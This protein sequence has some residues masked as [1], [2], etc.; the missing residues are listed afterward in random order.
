MLFVWGNASTTAPKGFLYL[1]DQPNTFTTKRS[2]E[3]FSR[4]IKS[5]IQGSRSSPPLSRDASS[6]TVI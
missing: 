3:A 4:D 5:L 6:N 2:E 1:G